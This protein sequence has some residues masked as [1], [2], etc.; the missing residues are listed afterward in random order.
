MK[1][2]ITVEIDTNDERDQEKTARILEL[3]EEINNLLKEES[4]TSKTQEVT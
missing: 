2:T 4:L 1:I 3:L